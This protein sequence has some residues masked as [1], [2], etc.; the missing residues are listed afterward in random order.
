MH[1]K[2]NT[3]VYINFTGA[4]LNDEHADDEEEEG[5]ERVCFGGF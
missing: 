1:E 5:G 4:F 3:Y 2:E